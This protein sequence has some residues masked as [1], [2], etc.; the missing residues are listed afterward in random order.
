MFGGY[1]GR[2]SKATFF[3]GQSI[4]TCS[5]IRGLL[6]ANDRCNFRGKDQGQRLSFVAAAFNL[7]IVFVVKKGLVVKVSAHSSYHLHSLNYSPPHFD[8]DSSFNRNFPRP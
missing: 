3:V 4:A 8:N 7:D 1:S 2:M 5:T 6:P